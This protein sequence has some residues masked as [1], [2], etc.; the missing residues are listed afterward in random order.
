MNDLLKLALHAHGGLN[1]WSLYTK[2]YA[3]IH[4]DGILFTAK[5]QTGVINEG[6]VE[7]ELREQHGRYIGFDRQPG[8]DAWFEPD[9][10]TFINKGEVIE[11]LSNPRASFRDHVD[12]RPA[13][14]R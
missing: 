14:Y 11:A 1:H 4:V 9:R 8:L 6:Q 5:G 3:L 10:I 2:V 13:R 7:L 12:L